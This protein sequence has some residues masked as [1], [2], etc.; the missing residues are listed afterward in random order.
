MAQLT[1]GVTEIHLKG[2]STCSVNNF[3]E[4]EAILEV[5]VHLFRPHKYIFNTYFRLS[6]QLKLTMKQAN[7]LEGGG[8]DGLLWSF[9]LFK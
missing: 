9:H 2:C 4:N 7:H 6:V 8:E 3:V 5:T 1:A